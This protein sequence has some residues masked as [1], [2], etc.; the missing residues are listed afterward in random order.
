MEYIILS[1]DIIKKYNVSYD[2]DSVIDLKNRVIEECSEIKHVN[3]DNSYYPFR[4][5]SNDKEYRNKIPKGTYEKNGQYYYKYEYDEYNYPYLVSLINR[6]INNDNTAIKEIFN[7]NGLYDYY[8]VDID[9]KINKLLLDISNE[10]INIDD[11]I[12]K[13]NDLKELL[14][15]Q[16]T[17]LLNDKVKNYYNELQELISFEL[18]DEI[19]YDEYKKVDKVLNLKYHFND[20]LY[21]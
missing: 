15:K 10:E 5:V 13:T 12:N 9:K 3:F 17:L 14:E 21:I 8:I 19:N 4:E 6:L 2:Y 11:K 1:N 18:I 16:K 20:N 7:Y